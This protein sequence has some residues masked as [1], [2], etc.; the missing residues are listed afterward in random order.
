MLKCIYCI[1]GKYSKVLRKISHEVQ[2][3]HACWCNKKFAKAC[4]VSSRTYAHSFT[5]VFYIIIFLSY[6]SK[7]Y[8]QKETVIADKCLIVVMCEDTRAVHFMSDSNMFVM[9]QS[10]HVPVTND[11]GNNVGN[12]ENSTT[13]TTTTTTTTNN[14]NINNNNNYNNN[15]ESINCNRLE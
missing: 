5:R 13:T 10:M 11:V 7:Y 2:N 4:G 9:C 1:F 8:S 6:N 15:N 3:T 14:N 12:K